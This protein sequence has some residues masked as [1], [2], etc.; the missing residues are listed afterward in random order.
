MMLSDSLRT[1]PQCSQLSGSACEWISQRVGRLYLVSPL[2]CNHV[3]KLK[4][5][6]CGNEAA[7]P[8]GFLQAMWQ[9]SSPLGDANLARR[10][11]SNYERPANVHIPAVWAE[12]KA[13]LA[14]LDNLPGYL[15]S[16]LTGSAILRK[17]GAL[18]DL[19]IVLR[20]DSAAAALRHTANLPKEIGGVKTDFF[21][22][23][24]KAPDVFFAC[25]DC[26][27]RKLYLS[28]WLPLKIETIEAGIE[29]VPAPASEFGGLIRRTLA[30]SDGKTGW[31]GV[32][33]E[34]ESLTKFVA[35][36]QSRGIIATA[37]HIAGL[38]ESDG[39]HV[40]RDTYQLRAKS[41]FGD[42]KQPPCPLLVTNAAGHRFCG[43]CG[44]GESKIARLDADT[45]EAYTKLHHPVLHCPLNREGFT[46]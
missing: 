36:V 38:N 46:R 34:W 1:F 41:C 12:V 24:G 20:F 9:R 45:A 4:G 16:M 8:E 5:P 2:V 31:I 7:S 44:C 3:C 25:L 35:A 14:H 18:K 22:Y 15:G 21:Y 28:G 27:A 26:E 33:K 37:K 10:V 40:D 29:I 23:I 32:T 13:A 39:L 43:A 11:A 17:S 42:G 6:Y 30:Q 19:D